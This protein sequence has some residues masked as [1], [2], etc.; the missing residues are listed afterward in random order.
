MN[1]VKGYKAFNKE[2]ENQYGEK[3]ECGKDYFVSGKIEGRFGRGYH[4]SKNFEETF[5]F[6]DFS[7]GAILT[8]VECS[9]KIYNF[10]DSY[11]DYD[12]Y[13]CSN[14][15]I[16]RI[17]PRKEIIEMIKN[18]KYKGSLEK[19]I[20]TFPLTKEE[21]KYLINESNYFKFTIDLMKNY[22]EKVKQLVK[23]IN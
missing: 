20:A 12:I 19:V 1:K 7:N 11:Y 17:I 14:M 13:S 22:D 10:Y 8:E 16:I 23:S 3:F 5:R 6:Y 2:L 18:I 4:F 9:G 21:F 15:K